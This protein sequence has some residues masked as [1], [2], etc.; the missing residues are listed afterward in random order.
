MDFGISSKCEEERCIVS[1]NGEINTATAYEFDSYMRAV[2]KKTHNVVLDFSEVRY[3]SSMGLRTIVFVGHE[4][5]NNGSLE[6]VN[7]SSVIMEVFDITG[8]TDNID[9]KPMEETK[10]SDI[11]AIFFDIDGTLL[12]HTQGAIPQSTIEA[13][14]E[15][16]SRGV[17]CVIATGRD[18]VEM[19]KLPIHDVDFD[20]Y[21]TLNGNVCLDANRK[22][23]AG[24]PIDPGETEVLAGIFNARRIPFILINSERRYINFVNDIVINTMLS[25]HGT[26]PE[27]GEYHGEKIY[28]CI[29]YVDDGMRQFLDRMLDNC[30]I[31]S[32]NETGIDIIATT[33][34]KD[35]GIQKFLDRYGIARSQTMAFG[36]GENDASMLQ[37]VQIGV[38]MGNAVKKLKN[39]A[40]YV[41][42]SVDDDGIKNALKHFGV[43]D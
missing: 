8:L 13:I 21:L 39:L 4:T 5:E 41:T 12:S 6:I 18:L 9:I 30:T 40:S 17:K 34:G 38:A 31:T 32:W 29:S 43:I 23:F 37:Y 36:D 1:I 27:T 28:Q 14:K 19:D 7:A 15:A 35:A 3:V 42:T 22:M 24:N 10:G 16:Q 2:L 20:G 26:V 33:G 25:T 11:K